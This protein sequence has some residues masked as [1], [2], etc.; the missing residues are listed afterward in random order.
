[1]RP[2]SVTHRIGAGGV[3]AI[4]PQLGLQPVDQLPLGSRPHGQP[5]GLC[6]IEDGGAIGQAVQILA[7]HLADALQVRQPRGIPRGGG[8]HRPQLGEEGG[9]SGAAGQP[10]VQHPPAPSGKIGQ[11][12]AR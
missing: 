10:G 1:M 4:Q 6:Q 11:L 9:G 3:F 7:H 5:I 12:V 8:E 2:S